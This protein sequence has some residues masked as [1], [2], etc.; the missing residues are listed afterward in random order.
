MHE[1]VIAIFCIC[2]EITKSFG[3]YSDAQSKMTTAEIM[4]FALISAMYYQ[5][6][7]RT[8]R[9]ISMPLKYFPK[10]LTHD[11]YLISLLG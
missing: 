1:K 6:D 8:T 9:L 11:C 4:S 10:I 3:L 7:Y 2:D 5:G